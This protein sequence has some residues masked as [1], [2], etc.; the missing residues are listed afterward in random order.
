MLLYIPEILKC[1]EYFRYVYLLVKRYQN[2]NTNIIFKKHQTPFNIFSQFFFTFTNNEFCNYIILIYLHTY[3]IYTIYN[4]QLYQIK[5]KMY[6][7]KVK[8]L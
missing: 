6:C 2:N 7:S 8:K 4:K 1:Y 5:C 3:N